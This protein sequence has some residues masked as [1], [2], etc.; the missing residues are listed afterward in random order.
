MLTKIS[1]NVCSIA[2]KHINMSTVSFDFP[3]VKVCK[4]K[5]LYIMEFLVFIKKYWANRYFIM[6][7]GLAFSEYKY[8]QKYF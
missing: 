4:S 5:V 8:E 6:Q 1:H 2:G 3:I 7:Q